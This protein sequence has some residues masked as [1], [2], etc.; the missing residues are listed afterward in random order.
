M[1]EQMGQCSQYLA[2]GS[3]HGKHH[4]GCWHFYHS[5]LSCSIIS[6]YSWVK[7]TYAYAP[8]VEHIKVA[9]CTLFHG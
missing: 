3:V 5:Y 8:Q 4:D 9:Q 1:G 2:Q 7:N 6:H